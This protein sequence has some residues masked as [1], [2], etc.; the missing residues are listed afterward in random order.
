M[1]LQ[2]IYP[3]KYPFKF[4]YYIIESNLLLYIDNLVLEVQTKHNH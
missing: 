3:N 1:I 4:N 2:K